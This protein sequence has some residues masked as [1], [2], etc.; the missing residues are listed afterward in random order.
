MRVKHDH[1]NT[2]EFPKKVRQSPATNVLEELESRFNN[3]LKPMPPEAKQGQET[4][5][6]YK[7][8]LSLDKFDPLKPKTQPAN[9]QQKSAKDQ[10]SSEKT[11]RADN[12]HGADS[13]KNAVKANLSPLEKDS[14]LDTNHQ[15]SKDASNN[16]VAE[17]PKTTTEAESDV[18]IPVK[19]NSL[20]EQAI[21]VQKRI[22]HE[23]SSHSAAATERPN[24]DKAPIENNDKNAAQSL[25]EKTPLNNTVGKHA[26]QQ[27]D[28]I[29]KTLSI[30]SSVAKEKMTRDSQADSEGSTASLDGLYHDPKDIIDGFPKGLNTQ[31]APIQLDGKAAT[32]MQNALNGQRLKPNTTV[33]EA[34]TLSNAQINTE[35]KA[36]LSAFEEKLKP[37]KRSDL[38]HSTSEVDTKLH[39]AA[40]IN[41]PA[42]QGDVVLKSMEAQT[43]HSS[44]R[45]VNELISKLVDK[46]YVS[47]PTAN[48]KE[49]RLFLNDG[50]LKGG[51]IS[52]KHDSSGYSVLIKQE[53]A[54]SLINPNAKQELVERLQRLGIEQPIRISVSEQMNQQ[55]DQQRSRQQR[56]IYDEW[57]PE[58]E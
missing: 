29:V 38:H 44:V 31:P 15:A 51:E 45:D 18:T 55:Q 39:S 23:N 26:Q 5:R 19:P 11:E 14:T 57:K 8:A 32:A 54:L 16:D 24:S 56:S 6:L 50:R 33:K 3:T 52:I 13:A 17:Q 25:S 10:A 34:V 27:E 1:P 46:I 49:V 37:L 42:T 48:E 21:G 35:A 58:G 12:T 40:N 20:V 7:A 22:K 41:Q 28:V 2:A 30:V 47:L 4:T 9:L 53:H 36:T 43:P